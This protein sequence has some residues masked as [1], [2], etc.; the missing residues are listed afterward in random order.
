MNAV[1]SSR[2]FAERQYISP[3]ID[4]GAR[5]LR[6]L[7][8]EA[9]EPLTPPAVGTAE[10]RAMIMADVRKDAALCLFVAFPTILLI[11]GGVLAL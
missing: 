8:A 6:K 2:T 11:I 9:N 10:Y 4:S 5:E 1:A 3:E 7:C